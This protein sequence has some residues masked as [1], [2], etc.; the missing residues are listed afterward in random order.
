MR[1]TRLLLL[2][3]LVTLGL[4]LSTHVVLAHDGSHEGEHQYR[5][6]DLPSLLDPTVSGEMPVSAAAQADF[7]PAAACSGGPVIDG[8]L[9]DECV[10]N[11]FSV[12]GVDKS[13]TVWYTQN[14]VTATR[15]VDGSPVVLSHWINTDAEAQQVAEWFENAWERFY[16]DSGHHL[17]D[18]GCDNNVNVQM[19]DG[20]GWSG[21]AYWASSGNCWIGI[22]S[23]MV[24]GGGG[25]W[26]VYHEAQH[27]LQYSWDNGC[28]GYL[29]PNYPDDSEFVEGYAD[30]GADSVN[31]TV[32]AAGYAGIGYNNHT[33][34]YDKS[35]GNLFLK[36]FIEQLGSYATPSDPWHNIDAMYAHYTECD[37][38]DTLYVLDSLIP[39]LSGGTLSRNQFFLNFFAANWAKNWADPATQEELIFYDDDGTFFTQPTLTQDV[40]MGGGSQTWSD[41]TPDD[42]AAR[43]YQVTPQ[44]GCPY[45]QMEVDGAA[46]ALLG[47]NFMA[48][49]TSAPTSVLRSA[50]IGN[51]YIRTFAANGVHNRLVAA[52]NSFNNNYSYDVTATCVTP[53]L[54]ILEPKQTSFAMVG[55][56]DSPIAFLARWAVT[57]GTAGVRGL[58]ASDFSF[59]IQGDAATI[60][61]GTFQAIGDEY[62]AVLLPPTKPADTT[63]A[64]LE[65]CLDG[66]ICD[67]EP[68]AV[69]YV[70]PGKSDIAMV[71][72]G[73]GS[74]AE[75]DIIG[76][77]TRLQNAQRA[78]LV[79]ADLLRPGDRILITDFSATD[80]PPGCGTESGGYDCPLDIITRLPRTDVPDPAGPTIANARNAINNT[81]AR[82]WTPI[83]PALLDAKNKILAAPTN[84]NPKHIFLLSD[85]EEN[86][87]P[88][89]AD[90]KAELIS[91]G[92]VINTISFGPESPGNLLAQIA[93]DTGGIYRPVPTTAA[94]ASVAAASIPA[95]MSAEIAS[96][97][98]APV[99]PGQL[100]LADVYDY[101]DTLAQDATR[102]FQQNFVGNGASC[103]WT[104]KSVHVDKLTNQLRFVLAAKQAEP[105]SWARATEV[106]PPTSG[107]DGRWIPISPPT[108]KIPAPAHWD[109]RNDAHNDVLIV[110]NPEPGTW[111]FRSCT[112]AVIF[113]ADASP[114]ALETHFMMAV[115]LQSEIRLQGQIMGL[116]DSQGEAGD[117]VTLLGYLLA[118]DGLLPAI[119][120]NARVV[121]GGGTSIVTLYDDGLHNDG[122]AGDAIYG[123]FF[124]QT[125]IGGGYDVKIMAEAKDPNDPASILVREWNGGFWI[126]GPRPEQEDSTGDKDG[127]GMPDEW[128][129]RC[130]LNPDDP[131]DAK[132]DPDRDSLN[133]L[134]EW[135]LGTLPCDPDTDNGGENDGSEARNQRDPLVPDDDNVPPL[136][137][138]NLR[139]LNQRLLVQWTPVISNVHVLLYWSTNMDDPGK[140]VDMGNDGDYMLEGLQNDTTYYVWLQPETSNGELGPLSQPEAVTPKADPDAPAGSVLIEN[141]AP[142]T[143]GKEVTLNLTSTDEM[144]DGAAQAANAHQTDMLSKLYNIASGHIEMRIAN[145]ADLAGATWEPLMQFKPWTLECQVGQVCRVYAQFRDEAGNE[146]LIISDEIMLVEAP[147]AP[148]TDIYLPLLSTP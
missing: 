19:E 147:A 44:A 41:T 144:L 28:Y 122:A 131:S 97:L 85:G 145:H 62:W 18:T 105:G 78:G 110:P 99:A 35:Y 31:A 42:F 15:M 17:Y 82:E 111:R 118:K 107:Q 21:I 7:G 36:Y 6:V 130:D 38:Q 76:E 72:D 67:T 109:I 46:G 65:I 51:G 13:V 20:V 116:N 48:A 69:L 86:V 138:I 22:D 56:P 49:K 64:N 119:S 58:Q 141:G 91:S 12:D 26:T 77:G 40:D 101:F 5:P 114:A 128:E 10:V 117:M 92:V 94:G 139:P 148:T 29:K 137:K 14:A 121:S 34:M 39:T 66:S 57:D 45:L 88:L 106:M 133:S 100:G 140:P 84:S 25:E 112:V 98:A 59:D 81:T 129:L 143:T 27:Y 127:D 142:Q 1:L 53:A 104:E 60:V 134:T 71:I 120:M 9:L 8:I 136:V 63:F 24:R 96:V 23:P 124:P 115:S 52:V 108:E 68:N 61:P 103:V 95:G 87:K 135:N 113:A 90:A 33:S 50:H 123:G 146:S 37:A 16:T 2:T 89:Y 83:T 75:E 3:A 47:I 55:A 126:K 80:N 93:A 30:L 43:Y 125:Y 32:D 74:M 54:N 102:I 70:D 73:S 11:T 79:I 4:A 132:L